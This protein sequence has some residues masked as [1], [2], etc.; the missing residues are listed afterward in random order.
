MIRAVQNSPIVK[1]KIKFWICSIN[2]FKERW[3]DHACM[4]KSAKWQKSM[5]SRRY[6]SVTVQVIKECAVDC[7]KLV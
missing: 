6:S 5:L 2:F 3:Q 4:H 7:L 1:K